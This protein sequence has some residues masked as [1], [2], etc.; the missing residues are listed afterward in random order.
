MSIGCIAERILISALALVGAVAWKVA[1]TTTLGPDG[2]ISPGQ[3][4]I[5]ESEPILGKLR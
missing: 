4:I 5:D 2:P 3:S 1:T